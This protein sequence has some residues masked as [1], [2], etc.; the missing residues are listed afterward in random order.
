MQRKTISTDYKKTK[1]FRTLLL[2]GEIV[3][4]AISVLRCASVQ[5]VA[6]P[7][8]EI[9]KEIENYTTE[10]RYISPEAYQQLLYS[11]VQIIGLGEERVILDVQGE[12]ENIGSLYG[13][14]AISFSTTQ[15]PKDMEKLLK[16]YKTAD[17]YGDYYNYVMTTTQRVVLCP[18]LHFNDNGPIGWITYGLTIQGID[19]IYPTENT[20]YINMLYNKRDRDS[21]VRLISDIVHETSHIFLEK[22]VESGKLPDF[23][24]SESYTERYAYIRQVNF[25]KSAVQDSEFY[26]VRDLLKW[27]INVMEKIIKRY[28][29]Q[30]GLPADDRTLFPR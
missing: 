12:V 19:P 28:N 20:I 26:A 15:M 10:P 14:R 27:Y 24:L 1:F 11:R 2:T 6:R 17:G 23:Y 5:P 25:L 30:L 22:L 4:S 13:V 9:V 7:V 21:I 8:V 18:G 29:F 16:K 3:V